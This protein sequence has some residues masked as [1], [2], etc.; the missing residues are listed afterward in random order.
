MAVRWG[1]RRWG[2]RRWGIRRW[3]IR[4]RTSR[5]P[6]RTATAESIG[7]T[8]GYGRDVMTAALTAARPKPST[9]GQWWVLTIRLVAPTL[10]NGEVLTAVVASVVFTAG[11]GG[12]VV[13]P[14]VRLGEGLQST[15]P[16]HADWPVD[17]AGCPHVSQRVPLRGWYSSRPYQW[18]CHRFSVLPRPGIHRGFLPLAA[19]DRRGAVISG[20]P[21][22]HQFKKP[23]GDYAMAAAAPADLRVA[24]RRHT[25][26]GG[27]CPVDPADCSQQ[28]DFPVRVRVARI[29][30]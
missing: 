30:W 28:A 7:K 6:A 8:V 22:G 1:T 2:T 20:R 23:G 13:V 26:R 10:R 5:F 4:R 12:G 29:G 14:H 16:V 3:G 19:S 9:L 15:I 11:G 17:T 24:F 18:S 27:L 25:T 21:A